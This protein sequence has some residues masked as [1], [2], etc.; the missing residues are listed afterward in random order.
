M[1]L[2]IKKKD[3]VIVLWGKDRGKTGEVLRVLPQDGKVL[4]AVIGPKR[5]DY[6]KTLKAFKNLKD[7][8]KN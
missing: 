4:V 2:R 7:E 5:M 8:L 6:D 3:T 1:A